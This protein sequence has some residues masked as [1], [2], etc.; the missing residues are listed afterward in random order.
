MADPSDEKPAESLP[1]DEWE[2]PRGRQAKPPFI[3][4]R[5]ADGPSDQAFLVLHDDISMANTELLARAVDDHLARGIR[6]MKID[7]SSVGFLSSPVV[8]ILV[9]A[10]E[11]TRKNGG[12]LVIVGAR[13]V[14]R[15]IFRILRIDQMLQQEENPDTA[16]PQPP[17]EEA[18]SA[19][20]KVPIPVGVPGSGR[21]LTTR[22]SIIK[23]LQI[24][25]VLEERPG[26]STSS[27]VVLA[28]KR[29]INSTNVRLF[30][31][32]LKLYSGEQ[33][34]EIRIDLSEIKFM[35]SSGLGTLV[36]TH[37]ILQR[38]GGKLVLQNPG[39]T[40]R[41]I[42]RVARIDQFVTVIE[43]SSER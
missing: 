43:T 42:L 12:S 21:S 37:R 23:R 26:D 11:T 36:T 1:E 3:E 8:P 2:A 7:M 17:I 31:E 40:M 34:L 22:S 18:V 39:Q 14:I 20:A 30:Q 6:Q 28:L 27:R 5:S 19:P 4:D 33:G 35:D 24:A 29:D 25:E 41:A 38:M 32:G 15:S 13:P 16:D 9:R 10:A